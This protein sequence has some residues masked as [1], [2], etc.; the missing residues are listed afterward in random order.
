MHSHLR[1]NFSE[2]TFTSFYSPRR[3]S[4]PK[5]CPTKV[6]PAVQVVQVVEGEVEVEVVEVAGVGMD[7]AETMVLVVPTALPVGAL[8][9]QVTR[10]IQDVLVG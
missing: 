9:I 2:T 5:L 1:S 6:V 7:T 8:L 4:V 10:E 3:R